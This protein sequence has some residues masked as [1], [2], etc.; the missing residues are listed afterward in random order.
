MGSFYKTLRVV[1]GPIP[2]LKLRYTLLM[3]QPV[4]LTRMPS[5]SAGQSSSRSSATRISCRSPCWSSRRVKLDLDHTPYFFEIVK[6]ITKLRP[7]KS[8]GSDGTLEKVFQQGN[9]VQDRV[10]R[11]EDLREVII[12][13]LYN[14]EAVTGE[15]RVAH[16]P[17]DHR[18]IHQFR[19]PERVLWHSE[20]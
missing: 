3:S 11:S 20:L 12:I 2:K 4:W 19:R 13:T 14:A 8:S 5:F 16:R 7:R 18:P 9:L 10:E 15:V 6:A 17:I 1:Y